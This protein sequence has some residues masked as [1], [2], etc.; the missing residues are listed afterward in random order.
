M[1][2][3]L[4]FD[5]ETV[6]CVASARNLLHLHNEEIPDDVIIQKL[7]EYHTNSFNNPFPRQ[8]FHKIVCISFMYCEIDV[9]DGKETYT[10]KEL[11][12]GGRNGEGEAEILEKFCNFIGKV[13]PRIISFNGKTFDM[14]V[15]QYRSMMNK[16]PSPWMHGFDFTYKYGTKIHIDL[17]DSFS[18]FGSSARVKMSEICA[19]LN[20]PCKQ[21]ASGDSVLSMYNNGQ[22]KE[23]CDYCESDV[24]ATYILYL[25]F[26]MHA[27]LISIE[28]MELCKAKALELM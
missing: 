22:I 12:T 3:L 7:V 14:P 2:N 27:G 17:L 1:K 28:T 25:Y 15:I 20:V 19:L 21:N 23:I 26:Q 18:N 24:V 11:K 10:I 8:L 5:I 16:I 6:P 9:I 13:K 4:V